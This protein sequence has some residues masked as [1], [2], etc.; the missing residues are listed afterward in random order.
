[1]RGFAVSPCLSTG[2]LF[3]AHPYRFRFK[4]LSCP[5]RTMYKE[6]LKP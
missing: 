4:I 5:Q 6:R 3:S 1:M 2:A